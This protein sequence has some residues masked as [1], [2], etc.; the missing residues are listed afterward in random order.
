MSNKAQSILR[1]LLYVLLLVPIL[2]IS[3][4][5]IVMIVVTIVLSSVFTTIPAW[6]GKRY[7][8]I[9]WASRILNWHPS[10]DTIRRVRDDFI[11][12]YATHMEIPS[13]DNLDEWGLSRKVD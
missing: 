7:S 5:F 1:L 9:T 3:L 12:I 4:F 8:A 6:I 11:E 2:L 13:D 10:H